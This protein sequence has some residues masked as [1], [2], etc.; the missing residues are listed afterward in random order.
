MNMSN[1]KNAIFAATTMAA[2]ILT[3][4][5]L[6]LSLNQQHAFAH[7]HTELAVNNSSENIGG[8]TEEKS[9][10]MVVG[11]T[12]EPTYGAEPGIH[13]GVH[14]LEIMLS[15]AATTL[16]LTNASLKADK[17]YFKDMQSFNNATTVE[18]ADQVVKNVT[19]SAVFGDPGHYVARQVMQPGI[20]GY[21][22][23]GNISYFGVAN[24]PVDT[25]VFCKADNGNTTKFNSEGWTGGFGCTADI[26]DTAFP[27]TNPT[28]VNSTAA[29]DDNGSAQSLKA[30]DAG[31][32]SDRS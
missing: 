9:V 11:H 6:P 13:D 29:D 24:V 25:T 4:A 27:R 15:D 2:L 26:N 32:G 16:P 21:H 3:A 5:A 7:A 1:K 23:Y 20:Y 31:P 17:Y 28:I 18:D 10:T 14:N 12:S 19:I 30:P 22:I 8:G